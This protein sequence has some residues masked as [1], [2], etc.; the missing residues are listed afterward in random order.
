LGNKKNA[1]RK[2]EVALGKAFPDNARTAV[3]NSLVND[4]HSLTAKGNLD[5]SELEIPARIIG[6]IQKVIAERRNSN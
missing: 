4:I 1:L 6:G 3:E 2:V 5:A